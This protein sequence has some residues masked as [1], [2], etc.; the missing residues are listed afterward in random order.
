MRFCRKT[1]VGLCR[2]LPATI[3][4]DVRI[5]TR[6]DGLTFSL[7]HIHDIRIKRL[8]LYITGNKRSYFDESEQGAGHNTKNSATNEL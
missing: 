2:Q 6:T 7:R 5:A 8:Y 4:T 1:H 3:E